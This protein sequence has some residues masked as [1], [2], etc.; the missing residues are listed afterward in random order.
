MSAGLDWEGTKK[1][2]KKK[3][4]SRNF[5]R[6]FAFSSDKWL[7]ARKKTKWV[8]GRRENEVLKLLFLPPTS[9]TGKKKGGGGKKRPFTG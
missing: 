6:K 5:W 3:K 9:F 1:R 8:E 7:K 2:K 4:N